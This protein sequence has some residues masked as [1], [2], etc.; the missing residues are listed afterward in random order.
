[1]IGVS[2]TG[3]LDEPARRP[4]DAALAVRLAPDTAQLAPARRFVRVA[5]ARWGLGEQAAQLELAASELVT[6]AILHGEGGID[7]TVELHGDRVR[8]AVEDEGFGTEPIRLREPT[9][10]GSGG[11]GLRLVDG[12]SDS[13][14]AHR[15]PGHTLVWME[16]RLPRDQRP[17]P[18]FAPPSRGHTLGGSGD[19]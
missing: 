15:A 13:W 7:V 18:G 11:W 9:Y 3:G 5:L 10:T 1:M 8:L 6:N 12:L 4:A 16:R 17:V 2:V 19:H 14:G